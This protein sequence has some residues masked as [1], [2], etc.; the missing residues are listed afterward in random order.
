[1]AKFGFGFGNFCFRGGFFGNHAEFFFC[2][3]AAGKFKVFFFGGK[4]FGFRLFFGKF[5]SAFF[6]SGISFGGI[7]RKGG[8]FFG[9]SG[10]FA[11]VMFNVVLANRRFC[12]KFTDG[13]FVFA[14]FFAF[15]FN[16]CVKVA[17]LF[18][19]GVYA[20]FRFVIIRVERI[21][22]ALENAD[23][24][25]LFR[26][27]S[28]KSAK[29]T[30]PDGNFKRFLFFRKFKELFGFFALFKKGA[31]ALFKGGKVVAKAKKVIVR[32]GKAFFSF[33]LAVT[34]F[35]NSGSFLE[36]FAALVRFCGN[37]FRNF[38]LADDGITV[39]AET[40]IHEKFVDILK[41]AAF[42]ADF[43]IGIAVAVIFSGNNN[44]VGI[45]SK[46]AVAVVKT[47]SD[48][49]KTVG[50]AK[51]GS[52]KNNVLHFSSAKGLGGHFAKNPANCVA[53]VTFS[54]SV[55]A[56]NCGH[57]AAEIKAGFIRKRFEARKLKIFKKQVFTS[58]F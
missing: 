29:G 13:G 34:E 2:N 18:V 52:V 39:S 22:F 48:F 56:N 19:K 40:G 8:N 50:M 42:F 26:K 5:G 44:F 36:N 55:G 27:L 47:D 10:N 4:F 45:V 6:K 53:Y 35:G 17:D 14:D 49:G 30:H 58:L 54:A 24:T 15:G 25:A 16:A 37:D 23:G 11:F 57:S 9:N 21:I 33:F 51:V 3:F 46:G 20:V 41:A 32:F 43:I 31:N 7:G 12:G 1:M 38:T 28:F